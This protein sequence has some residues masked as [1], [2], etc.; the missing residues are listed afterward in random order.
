MGAAT[1]DKGG[2]IF[3]TAEELLATSKPDAYGTDQGTFSC[4][5]GAQDEIETRTWLNGSFGIGHE[6]FY[7]YLHDGSTKELSVGMGVVNGL[8]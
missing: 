5:I 3:C 6:V 7:L 8:I 2:H 1:S 4:S